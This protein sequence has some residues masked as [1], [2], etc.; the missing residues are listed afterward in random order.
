MR[1]SCSLLPAPVAV[2]V[3]LLALHCFA[4]GGAAHA[5]DLLVVENGLKPW[6]SGHG[7]QPPPVGSLVRVN[8]SGARQLVATGLV[9]PVWVV[10]SSDGADAY[11]GLFHS[12]ESR[13]HPFARELCIEGA[14]STSDVPV[15]FVFS[16]KS[17]PT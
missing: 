7:E 14:E 5:A 4:G 2:A 11:V 16:R 6:P 15:C 12:G 1:A 8:A 9:D 13:G 17:F 10:G 3:T